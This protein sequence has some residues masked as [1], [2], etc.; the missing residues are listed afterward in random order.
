VR[1][2]AV[3]L[4][5]ALASARAARAQQL[6]P[7]AYLPAPTGVNVAGASNALTSGDVSFDPSLPIDE[8]SATID[9]IAFTYTRTFGLA[10]RFANAVVAVPV[11]AGHLRGRYLGEFQQI[12]RYGIGD[13]PV[14]L[15]VNLYGAPALSLKDFA[16]RPRGAILG[17]SLTAVVPVGQYDSSK[18]INIGN[19]RWAFKPE[20]GFA[21]VVGRWLFETY[22]GVWLFTDND[23]FHNGG[24][25][26][27]RPLYSAQ[28]H[29]HYAFR[30]GMWV[31]FNSNFYEGGQ[32]SVNHHLNLDFQKNSRLGA[33][34]ALP[35]GRSQQVRFSISQG[36]YTTIGGDFLSVGASYQYAWGGR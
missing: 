23:D 7:G 8:A 29:V 27:Q 36:V 15:G 17:A 34:F 9:T 16:K 1:A 35:A 30:P 13:V 11:V 14:R 18:L 26:E 10:G 6:T 3:A 19:H 12:E 31:A 5:V 21:K 32:T 22:G 33:T 28:F 4:V 20:L 24:V 25:R 2:R